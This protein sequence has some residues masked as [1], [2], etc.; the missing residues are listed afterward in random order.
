M[1][2]VLINYLIA[3]L[4]LIIFFILKKDD[5]YLIDF[6]I[7]FNTNFF[8][9]LIFKTLSLILISIRWNF[10]CIKNS[11]NSNFFYSFM[12]INIGHFLSFFTPGMFAQDVVKF[13]FIGKLNNFI[14]KKDIFIISIYDRLVG[15]IAFFIL[16]IS[17]IFF[18]IFYSGNFV[19]FLE[20]IDLL[21]LSKLN[22]FNFL[23]FFFFLCIFFFRKSIYK[24]FFRVSRRFKK[25]YKL[26]SKMFLLAIFGHLTNLIG[27]TFLILE[28]SNFD[29]IMNS[30]LIS[31]S[32]FG[33]LFPF[34]P[35]GMG[36]T[37]LFFQEMY[38][39][40]ENTRGFTIGVIIRYHSILLALLLTIS[41]CFIY[42]YYR[43]VNNE[44]NKN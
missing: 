37:E 6:K 34:T 28:V 10:L 25:I 30:A 5:L 33:H 39:L 44:K 24:S 31:I 16:N 11:L 21:N 14:N 41:S 3:L 40:F 15:L 29:F 12:Q 17:I 13:Y 8:L 35:S 32:L 2:R 19:V 22:L 38:H 27:I 4:I 20:Y 1:L 42:I 43:I 7:S 36:I 23:F 9:F 26:F 18:W